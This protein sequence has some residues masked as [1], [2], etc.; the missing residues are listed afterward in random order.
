LE[1]ELEGASIMIVDDADDEILTDNVGISE[2]V[3][4][5]VRGGTDI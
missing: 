3:Q 5:L 4:V 2:R 1:V